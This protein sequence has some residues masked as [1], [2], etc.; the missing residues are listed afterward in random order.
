MHLFLSNGDGKIDIIIGHISYG[1]RFIKDSDAKENKQRGH[2][3]GPFHSQR[4]VG[5]QVT[6]KKIK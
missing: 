4:E 2:G 1:R 5:K 6:V 3:L